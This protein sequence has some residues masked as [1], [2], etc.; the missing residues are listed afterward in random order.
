[1]SDYV[2][3]ILSVWGFDN[4]N[5]ENNN[6]TKITDEFRDQAKVYGGSLRNSYFLQDLSVTLYSA[7][8][9]YVLGMQ[10]LHA[11]I[12]HGNYVLV[13]MVSY[14]IGNLFFRIVDEYTVKSG[15]TTPVNQVVNLVHLIY[16][17]SRT[18]DEQLIRSYRQ[19]TAIFEQICD[20]A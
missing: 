5:L 2:T 14:K 16:I 20:K 10:T 19:F 4:K 8:V 3:N 1:M 18:I 12:T 13:F 9:L 6:L 15:R 17:N 11:S 7:F